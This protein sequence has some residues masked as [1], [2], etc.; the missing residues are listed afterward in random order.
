MREALQD[1]PETPFKQP[2]G[3]KR[4]TIC[5]QTGLL[6]TPYCPNRGQ[7]LFLG[8]HL[9]ISRAMFTRTAPKSSSRTWWG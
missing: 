4:A 7:G 3:L 9:P 8:G 5:L 2:N 6:A 1:T